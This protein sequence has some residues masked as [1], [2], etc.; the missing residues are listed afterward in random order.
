MNILNFKRSA[1]CF[2]INI[3]LKIAS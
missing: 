2:Q 3:A 1:E